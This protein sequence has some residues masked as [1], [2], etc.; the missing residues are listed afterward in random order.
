MPISGNYDETFCK[1]LKMFQWTS[2][3]DKK[4][5]QETFESSS[6]LNFEQLLEWFF[7]KMI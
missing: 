3:S 4:I 7:E 2:Q 5:S 1:I 6:L